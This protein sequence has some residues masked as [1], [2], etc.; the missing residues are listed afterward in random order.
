MGSQLDGDG[1]QRHK[2]FNRQIFDAI[3]V[4]IRNCLHFCHV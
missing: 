4:V 3:N 2:E 1:K